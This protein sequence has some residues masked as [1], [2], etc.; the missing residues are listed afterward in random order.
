[1]AC[2]CCVKYI[3]CDARCGL[4]VQFRQGGLDCG[5]VCS[6]L[7][8]GAIQWLKSLKYSGNIEG[9][10]D[11]GETADVHQPHAFGKRMRGE[12]GSHPAPSD[13][14]EMVAKIAEV[15]EWPQALGVTDALIDTM[16]MCCGV[17]ETVLLRD[18]VAHAFRDCVSRYRGFVSAQSILKVV[19]TALQRFESV[20]HQHIGCC[21]VVALCL[22]FHPRTAN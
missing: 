3:V 4:G 8:H 18:G 13:M 9:Q 2:N 14:H 15:P 22:C 19:L 20:R 10:G 12:S 7:H 16:K 1:M 21:P 17:R 5:I 6:V 11:Y